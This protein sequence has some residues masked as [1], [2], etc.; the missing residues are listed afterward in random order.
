MALDLLNSSNLEQ[1]A[2]KGLTKLQRRTGQGRK[3]LAIVGAHGE[4]GAQADNELWGLA[5][6]GVHG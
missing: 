2:F 6:R 4:R 1:L 3:L 5:P